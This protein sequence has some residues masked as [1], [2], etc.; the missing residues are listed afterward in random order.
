MGL[1]KA[2]VGSVGGVLADTWREF[3]YCDADVLNE[4]VLAA[5]GQK[6]TSERGRSSNT[7]RDENIISNGSVV[8]V[9]DGQ[10]MII[11][12]QGE[13]VEV[14]AEPGEFVW[15]TSTEP[16]IF[17][18]PLGTSIVD[19]FKRIGARFGFGGDTGKDQR[20][21]YF[22]T[23]EIYGNKY[24]TSSPIPFR[25]VDANLGLDWDTTVRMNGEY[26][27]KLVDPL[28][29]YKNVCGN[30]EEPYTRDRIESQMKSE[31]LTA[32]QP[33]LA[34]ISEK[35]IRYAAIPAHTQDLAQAL[36]EVLSEEWTQQ[37][38]IKVERFGINSISLPEDIEKQ[39]S[40]RQMAQTMVDPRQAAAVT[41]AATADAMRTAA[42]NEN[43]AIGAFMGMGMANGMGGGAAAQMFQQGQGGA[44]VSPSAY[45][46]APDG[47]FG[48][49]MG[50]VAGG[51]A[52]SAA[53][54]PA[55]TGEPVI[56]ADM[57][58][59]SQCGTSNAGKFCQ[60]CGAKRPE[61]P[62]PWTC[63]QCGTA[64][65]GKFCSECGSPRS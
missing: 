50:A 64:N 53:D 21:Y 41:A 57:W 27:Y 49:G 15:D 44:P 60:E 43:G 46:I 22:N 61:V 6:R 34:Q 65:A 12:E 62:Q 54:V 3:F 42:A 18:G 55:P 8:A 56:P 51:V 30:V 45:P 48:G 36:N 31:L 7:K 19:T 11:V 5:K 63:P 10:C 29:F 32:L 2:G 33:A 38:G 1:I 26:S 40:D 9:N 39:L 25:I 24:G 17:Y 59:C 16:S 35:G 14:C 47:G 4:N 37:R 28:I 13:I 52:G 23:K 20:V 58:T